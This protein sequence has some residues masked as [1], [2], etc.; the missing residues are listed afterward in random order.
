[1]LYTSLTNCFFCYPLHTGN[2]QRAQN[3]T[4]HMTGCLQTCGADSDCNDPNFSNCHWGKCLSQAFVEP[5]LIGGPT[6]FEATGV[7]YA[8]ACAYPQTAE[9]SGV[10][11][12][13]T[14]S[15]CLATQFPCIVASPTGCEYGCSPAA[16]EITNE[17]YSL[18]ASS[19]VSTHAVH[20]TVAT[21]Q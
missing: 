17:K 1:M 5:F 6:T 4:G 10:T 3:G 20:V 11:V 12:Y 15:P 21:N 2:P 16:W 8:D 19:E 7:E 13:D 14:C 18:A 9:T